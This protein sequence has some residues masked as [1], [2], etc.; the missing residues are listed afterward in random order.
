VPICVSWQTRFIDPDQQFAARH[1]TG[2]GKKSEKPR[3]FIKNY[4]ERYYRKQLLALP[5]YVPEATRRGSRS[6][7]VAVAITSIYFLE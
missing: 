4:D 3:E 7:K 5:E 2:G 1:A 6:M